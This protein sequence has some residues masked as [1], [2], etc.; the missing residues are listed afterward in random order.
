MGCNGINSHIT[1]GCCSGLHTEIKSILINPENRRCYN[2][3]GEY[4][5]IADMKI[6]DGSL[7]VTAITRSLDDSDNRTVNYK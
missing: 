4:I 2:E 3:D 7:T 6:V 5:G 1:I